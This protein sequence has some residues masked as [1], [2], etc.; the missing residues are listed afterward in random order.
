[1]TATSETRR[2]KNRRETTQRILETAWALCRRNGLAGL[3]FRE[4]AREVGLRAPSLYS[5]FDSKNDIYDAMF[6]QAAQQLVGLVDDFD[7]DAPP[8]RETMKATTRLWFEFCTADP[9]RYQLLFQRVVPDFE[10]SAE[11]YAPA[12]EAL[13]ITRRGLGTVGADSAAALDM[14]TA[15]SSGLTSQQISNDPGGDRWERLIDDAVDMYLNYFGE[16]VF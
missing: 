9:V 11:A 1:M 4:I 13:E 7:L 2:E 16:E 6:E 8:S 12:V 10:P 15:L 5:Y 3:S 14:W